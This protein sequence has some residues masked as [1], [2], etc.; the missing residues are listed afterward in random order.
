LDGKAKL[1]TKR[2]VEKVTSFFKN[3]I[4]KYTPSSS[5][6]PAYEWSEESRSE[7]VEITILLIISSSGVLPIDISTFSKQ[8]LKSGKPDNHKNH[9]LCFSSIIN[10]QIDP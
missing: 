7:I 10:P 3:D 2:K 8:S 4:P 1:R 9:A 6:N 5:D